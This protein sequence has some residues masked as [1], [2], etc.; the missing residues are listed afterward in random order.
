[1]EGPT[2]V[3]AFLHSATMVI[4]GIY[5][6]FKISLLFT[7]IINIYS[8]IIILIAIFTIFISSLNGI[9]SYDIKSI[10]ASSTS[11][12]IGYM[13]LAVGNFYN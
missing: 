13:F 6:L 7:S 9:F 12:Q 10:L 2:P 1:M 8:T 4:I 3:S 5:L 11:G